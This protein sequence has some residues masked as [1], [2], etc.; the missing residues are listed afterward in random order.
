MQA[1]ERKLLATPEKGEVSALLVRPEN[2]KYVLV[3][4][5]GAGTNARYAPVQAVAEQ[6][7]SVINPRG[8]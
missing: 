8:R 1:N 7:A 5:H 3:L 4:G 6:L 2:A